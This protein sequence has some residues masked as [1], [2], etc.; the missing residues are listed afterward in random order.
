MTGDYQCCVQN[1]INGQ[2]GCKVHDYVD[3]IVV[4]LRKK[5]TLH[6][7]L[8]ETFGNLRVYKMTLNPTKCV[9]VV[10]VGKLLGFPVSERGI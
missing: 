3:D 2:I 5:E 9:F 10:P 6:D 8:K 4:Q 7:D 1:C